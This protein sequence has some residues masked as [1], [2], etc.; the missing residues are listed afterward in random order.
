MF[1]V[2][3]WRKHKELI[4]LVGFLSLACGM[5]LASIAYGLYQKPDVRINKS[6]ETPPWERVDP[7]EQQKFFKTNMEY[8]QIPELEKLR[9]EIGSYKY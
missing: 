7:K 4:P 6:A 2:Q 9:G 5:G 8:K 3:F 1:G